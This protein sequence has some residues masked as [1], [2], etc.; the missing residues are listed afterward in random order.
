M[1]VATYTK[2]LALTRERHGGGISSGLNV[3]RA[4]NQRESARSQAEQVQAQRALVEHAIAA[5]IG[6]PASGF[7]IA[8]RLADMSLPQV[9]VDL[10]STL[11]QR[12]PDIAAAQRRIEAANADVGVVRAGYF[13]S[14]VLGVTGGYQSVDASNLIN[15]PNIFWAIGSS[16]AVNLFDAGRRRAQEAQARAVLDEMGANYRGVVLTA[17][18]QVEDNLAL[19]N[20]YHTAARSE[21]DALAAVRNLLEYATNR[22]REG[23]INY[24]DVV[25]SQTAALLAERNALDLET[26]QLRASVQLIRALGGGWNAGEADSVARPAPAAPAS[27]AFP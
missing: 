5:L 23:T 4:K 18:R 26:R 7:S 16:L 21:K 10:P 27:W 11:L 6:A 19:L 9:P 17:F 24:L 15:A 13:P 25:A 8:P 14:V 22:Y 3:A 12:R 20:H 2:A 1:T